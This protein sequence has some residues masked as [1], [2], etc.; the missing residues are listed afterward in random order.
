MHID[1]LLLFR[2]AYLRRP[3]PPASAAAPSSATAVESATAAAGKAPVTIHLGATAALIHTS[4]GSAIASAGRAT[5]PIS[6]VIAAALSGAWPSGWRCLGRASG[7]RL[8]VRSAGLAWPIPA[9]A[10]RPALPGPS[11]LAVPC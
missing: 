4:E 1:L 8:A 2:E 11:R 6:D 10:P 5:T 9:G 3:P 7:C